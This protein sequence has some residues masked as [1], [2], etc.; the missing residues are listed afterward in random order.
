VET[1][2][3]NLLMTEHHHHHA[4]HHEHHEH[5]DHDHHDHE[6]HHHDHHTDPRGSAP[7]RLVEVQESVL[8]KNDRLAA[9]LREELRRRRV[10][11]LNLLSGPGAGKTTLLERT[12]EALLPAGPVSVLEGD[13]ETS[14][15]AERVRAAGAQATQINTGPGC[16][17]DATM[18]EAGLRTLSLPER[19]VLFIENVGNLICPALFD[20]GERAKVVLLSVTEGED[21]PLKYPHIFRAARVLVLSK[22]D[23]LPHLTFDVDRC[24]ANARQMNPR[25]RVFQVSARTGAGMSTWCDWIRAEL[26]EARA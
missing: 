17:L 16:H 12:I 19:S 21:K 7:T 24:L 22:V 8:A 10:L 26:A 2:R 15:D 5:H 9:R 1:H 20:L 14:R 23:L 6:H 13:Q 25:L 4:D 3:H 18:I 11:A